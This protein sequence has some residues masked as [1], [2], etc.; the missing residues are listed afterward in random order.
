M[1]YIRF[2][3]LLFLLLPEFLQA[4]NHTL[5]IMDFIRL[6]DKDNFLPAVKR[7]L[8]ACSGEKANTLAF[9]RGTYHFRISPELKQDE[10]FSVRNFRNLTIEGNGSTFIFHGYMSIGSI[11]SSR[12]I[13]LQN[14]SVDWERPLISQG[15]ILATADN[16]I[17]IRIDK[18]AYPYRIVDERIVF[19]GEGWEKGVYWHNLYDKEKKEILYRTLDMPL[20][21][22]L[23]SDYPVKEVEP[24]I[25]RISAP[26]P[27]KVEPGTIITLWHGRYIKNG[28][29]IR[30][31]SRIT[32]DNIHIYHALSNGILGTRSEDITLNRVNMEANEQKGRVFSLVADAFHFNTCKGLIKVTGCCHSGQGD[33]FINIHGMNIR[34][35]ERIDDLTVAIASSGKASS[36]ETLGEGDELWFIN[37]ETSQR[38]EIRKIQSVTPRYTEGH[39]TGYTVRFTRS[40]PAEILPGDFM[41]NKTWSP[42]VQISHCRILKKHRA[43]GILVSTPGR[44][45]IEDNYFRTAGTAVLIEGD[46]NYW[47]E[48]GACTDVS[49]RHNVFEDCFTSGWGEGVITVTPSYQPSGPESKAYHRNI[50]ICDNVFRHFDWSIV[51]ARS[52]ENLVFSRNQI[53]KTDSYPPFHRKVGFYLDGCRKVVF[54]DNRYDNRFSGKNVLIRRMKS[55]DILI[56]DPELTL[57]TE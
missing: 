13:R 43:R 18:E 49:I 27:F 28:I 54:R 19:T 15:E 14:F 25:I 40:L 39:L 30:E 29:A 24:G 57:S 9:P 11:V 2:Y 36:R 45:V 42:D 56:R 53:E 10:G 32:L 48:S 37:K 50:S 21:E 3:I 5:S 8:D 16:G 6:E 38:G 22:K 33:D 1:K 17:D 7:A 44:V 47:F 55:K 52:V 31:S 4:A 34:I 41:E 12:N 46:T 20:G 51:Y 23:F 35:T 26:V